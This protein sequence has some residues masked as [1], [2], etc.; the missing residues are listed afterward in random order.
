LIQI[1]NSKNG[2]IIMDI[3]TLKIEQ[4]VLFKSKTEFNVLKVMEI[5]SFDMKRS[6]H[7]V[8]LKEK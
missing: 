7:Y 3:S 2:R 1:E 8:T 6:V 5:P 4:E